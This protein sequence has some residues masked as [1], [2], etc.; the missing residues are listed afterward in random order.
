MVVAAFGPGVGNSCKIHIVD[1]IGTF[2]TSGLG[3]GRGWSNTAPDR[4]KGRRGS[5]AF[6]VDDETYDAF[7]FGALSPNRTF[8]LSQLLLKLL[9]ETW[10]DN[11]LEMHRKRTVCRVVYTG[12]SCKAGRFDSSGKVDKMRRVGTAA[13]EGTY[14]EGSDTRFH[15]HNTEEPAFAAL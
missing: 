8:V 2:P 14:T 12:Y 3:L 5:A 4:V 9:P 7:P 6:V 15:S 10:Q 1:S 13:F 11:Y